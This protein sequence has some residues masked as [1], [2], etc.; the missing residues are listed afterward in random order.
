MQTIYE[1][2][3]KFVVLSVKI[4]KQ[5]LSYRVLILNDKNIDTK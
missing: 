1:N 3:L 2:Q 4:I 5:M